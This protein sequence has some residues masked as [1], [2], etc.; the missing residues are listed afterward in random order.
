MGAVAFMLKDLKKK[1]R[2]REK[3]EESGERGFIYV[4]ELSGWGTC[5]VSFAGVQSRLGVA[6][7]SWTGQAMQIL[8]ENV[9]KTWGLPSSFTCDS[10][11]L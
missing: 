11:R 3:E 10:S 6:T 2:K 4:W 5:A 1:G 9:G 8:G 7:S